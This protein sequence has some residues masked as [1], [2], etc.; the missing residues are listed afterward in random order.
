MPLEVSTKMLQNI[1]VTVA[2]VKEEVRDDLV[3]TKEELK[4]L[5]LRFKDLS[6]PEKQELYEYVKMMQV[7]DPELVQ[8]VR[9]EIR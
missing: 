6:E 8:G 3:L 4:T 7:K 1:L 2:G 5:V 9:N